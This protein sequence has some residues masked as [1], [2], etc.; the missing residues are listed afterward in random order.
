MRV[1]QGMVYQ[2][3]GTFPRHLHRHRPGSHRRRQSIVTVTGNAQP[4]AGIGGPIT[5][6]EGASTFFGSTSTDPNNDPLTYRWTFGDGTTST[7]QNPSHTYVDNGVYN[8][9]LTV[10]DPKGLSSSASTTATISNVAPSAIT[11]LT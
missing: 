4:N 8:V 3:Y 6:K 10:K 2:D 1:R 9:T 11:A 5:G 7:S